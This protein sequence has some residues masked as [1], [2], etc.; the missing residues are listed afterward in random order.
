MITGLTHTGL[1]VKDMDQ[2]ISFYSEN[3]GFQKVLDTQ[4]G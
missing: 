3:F 2:M 4:V 1:V